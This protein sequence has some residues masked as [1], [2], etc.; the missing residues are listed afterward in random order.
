MIFSPG[1][2]PRLRV[3][4][5]IPPK[6]GPLKITSDRPS[7]AT[8]LQEEN[9]FFKFQGD[10]SLRTQPR[11][12][13][14]FLAVF[15][16]PLLFCVGLFPENGCRFFLNDGGRDPIISG[17]SVVQNRFMLA[18]NSAWCPVSAVQPSVQAPQ[19]LTPQ[20]PGKNAEHTQGSLPKKWG[21]ENSGQRL[22]NFSDPIFLPKRWAV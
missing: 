14:P 15:V 6:T 3:A 7:Q 22:K 21:A 20:R 18:P 16:P 17:P 4:V 8:C 11:S 2:S 5:V 12:N 19:P 13:R 1:E 10:P 9:Y